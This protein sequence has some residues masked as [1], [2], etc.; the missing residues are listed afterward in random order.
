MLELLP[1]FYWVHV[2]APGQVIIIIL[3]IDFN[4]TFL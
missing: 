4:H 1:H 3:R 2:D